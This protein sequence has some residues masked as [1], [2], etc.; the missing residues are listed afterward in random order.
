MSTEGKYLDLFFL[1]VWE[2][3]IRSSEKDQ[4][5]TGK[6]VSRPSQIM[7]ATYLTL[8][9]LTTFTPWN[10]NPGVTITASGTGHS[11]KCRDAMNLVGEA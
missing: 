4:K 8:Q 11:Y 1:L 2:G 6:N 3:E 5:V 9:S 10:K 7:Q